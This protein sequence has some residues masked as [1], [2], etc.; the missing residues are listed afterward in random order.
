MTDWILAFVALVGV[1][2][3]FLPLILTVPAPALI[4]VLCMVI[5]MAGYDFIRELRGQR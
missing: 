2:A 5:A 3:Y 4:V 1:I